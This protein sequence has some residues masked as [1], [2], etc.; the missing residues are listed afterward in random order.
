[1]GKWSLDDFL[2]S[3]SITEILSLKKKI[4]VIHPE[5]SSEEYALLDEDAVIAIAL[6]KVEELDDID[7]EEEIPEDVVEEFDLSMLDD[8]YH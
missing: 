6:E 3:L 1:M 5:L 7:I 2:K 4:S 8:L